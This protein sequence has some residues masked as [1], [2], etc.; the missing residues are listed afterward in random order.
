[1]LGEGLSNLDS[2]VF[3]TRAKEASRAGI[4]HLHPRGPGAR[5]AGLGGEGGAYLAYQLAGGEGR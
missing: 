3:L 4:L 5:W 2:G 1:M